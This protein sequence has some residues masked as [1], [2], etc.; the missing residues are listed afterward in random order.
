MAEVNQDLL[1]LAGII[2]RITLDRSGEMS[3]SPIHA[4]LLLDTDS[5][6]VAANNGAI[7]SFVIRNAGGLFRKDSD[8]PRQFGRYYCD[9]VKAKHNNSGFFTTDELPRYGLSAGLRPKILEPFGGDVELDVGV[10]SVYRRMES[11]AVRETLLTEF[12]RLASLPGLSLAV[13]DEGPSPVER[14]RRN[15]LVA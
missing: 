4:S 5:T 3:F 10:I 6:L 1:T 15:H 11:L 7:H 12:Q 2:E 14:P 13:S 9:L 8:E